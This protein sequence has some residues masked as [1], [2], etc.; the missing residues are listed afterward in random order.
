MA[1]ILDPD[2]SDEMEKQMSKRE[3]TVV[4]G[5]GHEAKQHIVQGVLEVGDVWTVLLDDG[6][7]VTAAFPTARINSITAMS[8]GA[9]VTAVLPTASITE[10]PDQ[11]P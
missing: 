8:D 3:Y 10:A 2:G 7:V 11:Y 9:A 5:F 1:S 6:G 4:A